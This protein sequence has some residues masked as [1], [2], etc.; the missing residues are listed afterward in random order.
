M[1]IVSLLGVAVFVFGVFLQL[2]TW[3]RQRRVR[4][5][6][7]AVSQVA[8][9][10]ASVAFSALTR[11]P[12][13]VEWWMVLLG[14]GVVLGVI[15]G[16]TMVIDRTERGVVMSYSIPAMVTWSALMVVTQLATIFGRSVPIVIYS[17][18][19]ANLGINLGMNGRVL[20]GYGTL[21]GAP[22]MGLL[23]LTIGLML[24]WSGIAPAEAAQIP[25]DCPEGS[26]LAILDAA[27]NEVPLGTP[28]ATFGC[29]PIEGGSTDTSIPAT[30]LNY[31]GTYRASFM[32]FVPEYWT[33]TMPFTLVVEESGAAFGNGSAIDSYTHGPG[34]ATVEVDFE[35][36][37]SIDAAGSGRCVGDAWSRVTVTS[38]DQPAYTQGGPGT[39]TMVLSIAPDGSLSGYA[40]DYL[41]GRTEGHTSPIEGRAVSGGP[42]VT[43]DAVPGTDS[44]VPDP[45]ETPGSDGSV[46]GSGVIP[47]EPLS[48]E[49]TAAAVALS[50]L[51][52]AGG[53]LA[54][55]LPLL[56]GG[57]SLQDAI[58]SATSQLESPLRVASSDPLAGLARTADGR[59]MFQPPWEVGGPIPIDAEE[60][61]RILDLQEQ[62][63]RW[64]GEAGGWMTPDQEDMNR[65]WEAR[66]RAADAADRDRFLAD[67]ARARADLQ[68][69]REALDA[70]KRAHQI[71]DD[72][73]RT[74][75]ERYEMLSDQ[76]YDLAF[77]PDGGIDVEYVRRM[78]AGLGTMLRSDL[79]VS[80]ESLR[81]TFVSDFAESTWDDARHS[82]LIRIGTGVVTGGQSEWFYQSQS[83][84]EAMDRAS[85]E[86]DLTVGD[87]LRI[88]YGT[89]AEENL[90]VTTIAKLA[91]GE[92]VGMLDVAG[93]LLKGVNVRT[94]ARGVIAEHVPDSAGLVAWQRRAI[95]T[96]A[97]AS[98]AQ[99]LFRPVNPGASK[100][101]GLPGKPPWMKQKTITADD[102]ALLGYPKNQIGQVPGA[103]PRPPTGFSNADEY[104][105]AMA[106]YNKR[107]AEW[108]EHGATTREAIEAG[109]VVEVDGVLHTVNPATN[110]PGAAFVA[111]LDPADVVTVGGQ[112]MSDEAAVRVMRNLEER[113]L[114]VGG[115]GS[116][117]TWNPT[118]DAARKMQA[119]LISDIE[120]GKTGEWFR[121]GEAA[122][123]RPRWTEGAV[124]AGVH[125]AGSPAP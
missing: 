26:R 19:I 65:A 112:R 82:A 119:G 17:L 77:T 76:M 31:A 81:Q 71:V 53:S 6:L 85:Q 5:G 34:P 38:P 118:T 116:P 59:V 113:G 61:R 35:C 55:L 95:Q 70:L 47:G 13:T 86:G 115:H 42:T 106:Q 92:D 104:R 28:G 49:D 1:R 23:A 43:S 124:G 108:A 122:G 121:P 16:G 2:R 87:G 66:A 45:G 18:A 63:Y 62:G 41:M 109:R 50:S 117:Y 94:Q 9:L 25:V 24:P 39:I 78:R 98:D 11:R 37:G 15:Y 93:D 51:I 48:D 57:M 90:P 12:P 73:S 74:G 56:Q 40:Q 101:A 7:I 111:D 22:A 96:E 29:L 114:A 14:A 44:S 91:R 99:L 20:W 97:T 100:A 10:G 27:G 46:P 102:V 3:R 120:A 72:S 105:Q 69:R 33:P 107:A 88:A 58:R 89:V 84:L 60:A 64:T 125:D 36:L 8:A 52:L 103:P 54:Q 32:V 123:A 83:V 110:K 21:R 4:P 80:D 30:G 68:E 67:Q 75:V 79:A